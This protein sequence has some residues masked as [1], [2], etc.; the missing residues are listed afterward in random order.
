MTTRTMDDL[1]AALVDAL[2]ANRAGTGCDDALRHLRRLHRP[3]FPVTTTP[4][5]AAR[6]TLEERRA[7]LRDGTWHPIDHSVATVRMPY[8]RWGHVRPTQVFR[9]KVARWDA[10]RGRFDFDRCRHNHT[11]RAAADRCAARTARYLNRLPATDR[12]RCGDLLTGHN[13]PAMGNRP[14]GGCDWCGCTAYRPT[15][16]ATTTEG[17]DR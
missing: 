11:A 5:A 6:E 14:A 7:R 17:T 10:D 2:D 9:A 8:D 16:P 1:N 4:D 3:D 13:A 15:D 12:C